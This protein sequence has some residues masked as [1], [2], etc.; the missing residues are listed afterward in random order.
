MCPGIIPG[1]GN[2]IIIII[3]VNDNDIPHL[4]HPVLRVQ[5][6]DAAPYASQARRDA[7]QHPIHIRPAYRHGRVPR[8]DLVIRLHLELELLPLLQISQLQQRRAVLVH[9]EQVDESQCTPQCHAEDPSRHLGDSGRAHGA[10]RCG[11]PRAARHPAEGRVQRAAEHDA[12]DSGE[13]LTDARGREGGQAECHAEGAVD[14]VSGVYH[15]C[16]VHEAKAYHGN[17]RAES[18]YRQLTRG[19]RRRPRSGGV[20]H[21]H[22]RRIYRRFYRCL[23]RRGEG[24]L[25]DHRFPDR[26]RR[27]FRRRGRGRNSNSTMSIVIIC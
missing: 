25:F 8:T 20:S 27:L 14:V 4:T 16:V 17:R 26:S 23:H 10:L 6:H 7:R 5:L 21:R 2:S 12:A 19:G 13:D 11:K 24:S 9:E 15:Y 3:L 22:R 18:V 1:G